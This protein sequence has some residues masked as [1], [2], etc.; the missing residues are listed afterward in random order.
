MDRFDPDPTMAAR[1]QQA[2]AQVPRLVARWDA[3]MTD[4]DLVKRVEH[5]LTQLVELLDRAARDVVAG[6]DLRQLVGTY[7][8]D[9]EAAFQDW[10]VLVS[11]ILA[12]APGAER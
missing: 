5:W 1:I 4:P 3:A 11:E 7:L 10:L 9:L 8:A 6:V 2:V 12:Y